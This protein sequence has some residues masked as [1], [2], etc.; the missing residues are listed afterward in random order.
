MPYLMSQYFI[1]M[2]QAHMCIMNNKPAELEL[3]ESRSG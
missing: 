1:N 3:R 2:F